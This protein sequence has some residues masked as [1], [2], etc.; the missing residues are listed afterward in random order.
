MVKKR[1]PLGLK[2]LKEVRSSL[3]RSSYAVGGFR[4]LYDVETKSLGVDLNREGQEVSDGLIDKLK[5]KKLDPEIA[6][7]V[8]ISAIRGSQAQHLSDAGFVLIKDGKDAPGQIQEQVAVMTK[9]KENNPENYA[10]DSMYNKAKKSLDRLINRI[11]L[12][13]QIFKESDV[14]SESMIKKIESNFPL[15][16]LSDNRLMQAGQ[17]IRIYQLLLLMI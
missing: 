7:N 13:Q 10:T 14:I 16:T 11:D 4:K 6:R 9:A 17:V 3:H 2:E 5:E 15:V 1:F 8:L 12:N